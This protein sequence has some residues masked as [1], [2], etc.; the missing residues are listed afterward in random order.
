VSHGYRFDSGGDPIIGPTN[1][2]AF[3]GRTP[4]S[5]VPDSGNAAFMLLAGLAS[6]FYFKRQMKEQQ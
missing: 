1:I 5:P 3:Y 6:L 4:F 2:A